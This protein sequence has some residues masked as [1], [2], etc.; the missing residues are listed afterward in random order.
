MATLSERVV[1]QDENLPIG[2][3]L[4]DNRTNN[5]LCCNHIGRQSVSGHLT[6]RIVITQLSAQAT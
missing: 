1:Y 2:N 5:L 6:N 3:N 4:L